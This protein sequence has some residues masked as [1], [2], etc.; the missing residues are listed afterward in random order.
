MSRHTHTQSQLQFSPFSERLNT[1][2]P[3]RGSDVMLSQRERER[4]Y[5]EISDDMAISGKE[6]ERRG[7][8]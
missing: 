6:G 2:Q 4:L 7:N 5:D 3:F 1:Q 8:A